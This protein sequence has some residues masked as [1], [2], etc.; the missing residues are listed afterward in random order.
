MAGH[1]GAHQEKHRLGLH[2]DFQEGSF[3]PEF[4]DDDGEGT[5]TYTLQLG[6][7][8]R[9]AT[10][11]WFQIDLT[12]NNLGDLTTTDAARILAM[13]FPFKNVA[14]QLPYFPCWGSSLALP[15]AQDTIGLLAVA[16]SSTMGF[17]IWEATA[18]P[19]TCLVSE[20]SA[21]AVLHISGHYEIDRLGVE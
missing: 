10:W 2:G 1:K 11:V 17:Q 4:G 5:N 16:N 6:R 9:L 3:T 7:F 19:N 8:L 15:V 18:G 20:I 21:G 13:P 14:T 12:I